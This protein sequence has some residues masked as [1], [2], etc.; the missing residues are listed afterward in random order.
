LTLNKP[1]YVLGGF[2][3][4]EADIYSPKKLQLL[5]KIKRKQQP[6]KKTCDTENPNK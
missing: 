1:T 5:I 2:A 4:T 3:A 6:L